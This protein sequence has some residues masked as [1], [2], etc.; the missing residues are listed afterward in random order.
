MRHI[1]SA[2]AMFILCSAALADDSAL[3]PAS[4]TASPIEP[5]VSVEARGSDVRDLIHSMFVQAK[6]EYV[7]DHTVKGTAHLILRDAPLSRAF[8]VIGEHASVQFALKDGIYHVSAR[9]KTAPPPAEIVV[10]PA[11]VDYLSKI[12]SLDVVRLPIADVAKALST[13]TGATLRIDPDVPAYRVSM[14]LSG[15]TLKYALTALANAAPL[16]Y[17]SEPGGA[18][19]IKSRPSLSVEGRKPI[20]PAVNKPIRAACRQCRKVP[21]VGWKW[22]PWCGAGLP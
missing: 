6:L 12:I 11:P 3:Q 15:K 14:S 19:R 17:A 20:V 2:V 5:Q 13:Q 7:L 10:K 21:S 18:I 9:P 16:A 4:S 8:Q 1:Y 22:C